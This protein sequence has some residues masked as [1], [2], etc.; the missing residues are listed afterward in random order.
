MGPTPVPSDCPGGSYN[1]CVSECPSDDQVVY[2][3]CVRSCARRCP[4]AP[5][6]TPT[7]VP[8][9][10]APS[11]APSDCPGGS[12]TA[13]I[14]LCPTDDVSLFHSCVKS[15]QR[16]CVGPTP[17]PSPPVPTPVPTPPTPVPVPSPSPA[18]GTCCWGWPLTCDGVQD[19][20]ADTFCDASEDS[21][22]SCGGVFCARVV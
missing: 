4:D 5:A 17:S 2:Q 12:L 13:C 9:P 16:R 10:P 20:H 8:T 18:G 3:A 22:K 14:D 21:C 15:C 19:C 1:A 6:P 11:P 7:P